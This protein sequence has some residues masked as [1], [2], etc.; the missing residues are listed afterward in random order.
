MV[1]TVVPKEIHVY[2][3]ES[4]QGKID[5]A[6]RGDT[7]IIHG[8]RYVERIDFKGKAITVRSTDPNNPDVV[9]ATIIDAN[10]T[11]SVVSACPKIIG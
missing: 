6:H 3:G 1:P 4:I 7:I 5:T 11:G 10:K 2:P 8:G 9:A